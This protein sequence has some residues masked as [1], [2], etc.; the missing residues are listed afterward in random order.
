M[1]STMRILIP[2]IWGCWAYSIKNTLPDNPEVATVRISSVYSFR[3]FFKALIHSTMPSSH[4]ACCR[5]GDFTQNKP[6]TREAW[7]EEHAEEARKG[8]PFSLVGSPQRFASQHSC[9]ASGTNC[10]TKRQTGNL[11]FEIKITS[12]T[13]WVLHKQITGKLIL[14]IQALHAC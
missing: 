1:F 3:S 8:V 4:R 11:G 13:S 12:T 10:L 14:L 6:E 2:I 9:P 5:A 7:H